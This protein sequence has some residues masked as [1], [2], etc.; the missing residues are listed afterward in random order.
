MTPLFVVIGQVREQSRVSLI[1]CGLS[2]G[3][4]RVGVP[5]YASVF[6]LPLNV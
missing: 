2:P 4:L 6:Y 3:A 5:C 1:A